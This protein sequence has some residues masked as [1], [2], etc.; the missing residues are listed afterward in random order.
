[1]EFPLN[2]FNE[3][4]RHGHVRITWGIRKWEKNRG[5]GGGWSGGR[6]KATKHSKRHQ[7]LPY[8]PKIV[9]QVIRLMYYLF[10]GG[11]G[12]MWRSLWPYCSASTT[13]TRAASM[14]RNS[15]IIATNFR[16][17]C[18]WHGTVCVFSCGLAACVVCCMKL[19]LRSESP[20]YVDVPCMTIHLLRNPRHSLF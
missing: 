18:P 1:M 13:S 4:D 6:V 20:L 16:A 8:V 19:L 9:N 3:F 10:R 12:T 5:D 17:F 11:L 15:S 14:L 2:L 7:Y